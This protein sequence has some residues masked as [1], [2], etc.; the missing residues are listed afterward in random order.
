VTNTQL[1]NTDCLSTMRVVLPPRQ[2]VMDCR[3]TTAMET[4]PKADGEGD[5]EVRGARRARLKNTEQ[6]R[7]RKR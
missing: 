4:A 7:R 2:T 5:G 6:R 1:V 3:P